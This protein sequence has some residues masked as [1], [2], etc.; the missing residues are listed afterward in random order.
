MQVVNRKKKISY[1][2]SIVG[3]HTEHVTLKKVSD[4]PIVNKYLL[5]VPKEYS[6]KPLTIKWKLKALGVKGSWSSN[7]ILDKRFRTDWEMPQV[8][9]SI[10]IDAPLISLYGYDDENIMAFACADAVNNLSFEAA[11]REED[12]HFYCSIHFFSKGQQAEDYS[13]EI[14]IDQ[15]KI[16]FS[17][18]IQN[19]ANWILKSNNLAKR[20]IPKASKV[21]LYST[22]YSFH[23]DLDET[24]LL[25]ECRLSKK[26][27]Y[28]LIIIDD[29][30]QTMDDNRGYDY[31]GDWQPDRFPDVKGFVEQVHDIGM[32]I[33][34]W[35]S[36]PFCGK[37]SKAYKKFKG[38]F[39]TENHYW[40]PVFDPRFPE[41]R[42]YL[43]ETYSKAL[44]DWNIDGLKLDFIDDF[45]LYP[46]SETKELN[47]R[48][49]L[50][51]AEGTLK[52]IQEINTALISIKPN[53]LIEFRQKYISPALHRVG[54]MFRA[55]DC[56]NDSLMNRVR[57]TD[58]KLICG[59]TAVH[60]DMITWHKEEPVE[61]AALQFS[62]MIFSVPQ[63]SIRL[64]E[65]REDEIQMIR[66]YTDY[67]IK[68]KEILLEGR[69]QAFKPLANYPYLSANGSDTLILGLYEDVVLP[70][71]V[72]DNKNIHIIN[73]KTT[74]SVVFS[75]SQELTD[76]NVTIFNCMGKEIKTS[77]KS[78]QSGINEIK[79]PPNGIVF[80]M[81]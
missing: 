74:E 21:P 43:V 77:K 66:F 52:L 62:S 70:L 76:W 64:A 17:S 81:K 36:V 69:F 10:S 61:I 44:I 7:A 29:G 57:T 41:V 18:V 72:A 19:V 58:V 22:W 31:T 50:S 32:H 54:N 16:N 67:W 46:E 49:T 24:E 55:F 3:T 37:K 47:G 38:K 75:L 71:A 79:C 28:D 68:H 34:F 40:A 73:G 25:K 80:L 4:N 23:Q 42:S 26:L 2:P 51:V 1:E 30:W 14:L 78:F 56:P 63:L 5:Q 9:S 6:D 48:D 8:E 65:R 12:N 45:K 33:M 39:L 59:K 35:Y 20:L 15:S 53:V 27:G 11:L 13:T 60:S